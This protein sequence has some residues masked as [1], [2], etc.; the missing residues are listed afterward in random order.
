[1]LCQFLLI[2]PVLMSVFVLLELKAILTGHVNY[3]KPVS[4]KVEKPT[5]D[6][7]VLKCL[8]HYFY[9][10][11]D[12]KP[13]IILQFDQEDIHAGLVTPTP[14]KS[15]RGRAKKISSPVY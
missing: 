10:K 14:V 2:C 12:F 7:Q 3:K 9:F 15:R 4:I 6:D 8:Q 13:F 11:L 1:M 5:E